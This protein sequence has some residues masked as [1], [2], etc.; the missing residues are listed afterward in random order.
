MNEALNL[1]SQRLARSWMQHDAGMLRDYLVSSVEDPRINL[2]SILTRHFLIQSVSGD[3]FA[4]VMEQECRFSAALNW[5]MNLARQS[6][7]PEELRVVQYALQHGSDNAEGIELPRFLLQTYASLPM[8]IDD[9]S[10][11]NYLDA[12]LTHATFVEGKIRFDAMALD[13]FIAIWAGS[14]RSRESSGQP[15]LSAIEPACG[16][17]IDYRFIRAAGIGSLVDYHGFDICQKN[18]E[19]ARALFPD[20]NVS[21]GNIFE[22]PRAD[23]SFDV[24]Y[25]H[26]LLEH[27]SLEGL[28]VAVAE[29][30]RVTRWGICAGFFN[31]NEIPETIEQPI[32]EYHWNVLSL[33]AVREL[34]LQHGF[35]ARV[36]HIGTVLV[37]RFGCAYTHNPNAYTFILSPV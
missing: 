7:N 27:L 26:D 29:I 14:M 19:N 33:D 20:I 1:E 6:A 18:V 30:C 25:F 24:C 8:A 5:L 28:A 37:Q 36:L 17:A 3:Q 21:E 22:I 31:M 11:P 16:S 12:A 35:N 10:I 2:Q 15:I 13:T 4:Q 9:V 34:F 32:D 23:K